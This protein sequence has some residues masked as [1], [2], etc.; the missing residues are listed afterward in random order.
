MLRVKRVYICKGKDVSNQLRQEHCM[1]YLLKSELFFDKKL[2]H[3]KQMNIR[4]VSMPLA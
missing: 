3:E 2:Q 4:W 1:M